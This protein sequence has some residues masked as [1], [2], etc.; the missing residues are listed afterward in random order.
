MEHTSA[1]LWEPL[2]GEDRPLLR[3]GAALRGKSSKET[4]DATLTLGGLAQWRPGHGENA[5]TLT[6]LVSPYLVDPDYGGLA[7]N[8]ALVLTFGGEVPLSSSTGNP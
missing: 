5:P 8:I 1:L 3:V 6:A 2:D 7:P 4:P